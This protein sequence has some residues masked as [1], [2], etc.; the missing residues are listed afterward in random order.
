M[1]LRTCL[2]A[3]LLPAILPAR[4]CLH[5]LKRPPLPNWPAPASVSVIVPTLNEAD[6]VGECLAA[7]YAEPEIT[8]II[9]VDGGSTDGTPEFAEPGGALV[10]RHVR[11][12]ADGGGRGGQ[13]AAGL[14]AAHGD[15]IAIVHADCRVTPGFARRLLQA[16]ADHPASPGGAVGAVFAADGLKFRLLELANNL[17]AMLLGI[18]FGDQIQ[19][20]RREPVARH[21][22][23]PAIPLMEDI[24]L[25]L[26]LATLG[27]LLFLRGTAQVSPRR[28]RTGAL[29][30]MFLVLRL[31]GEYLAD[32]LT[33]TADPVRM[34]RDYYGGSGSPG[35]L[36]VFARYP[37]PGKVKARLA[38]ELGAEKAARIYERGTRQLLQ[39]LAAAG[40]A[41]R[42][43]GTGAPPAAF[44]AKYGMAH[45]YRAQDEAGDLGARML[46]C[47]RRETRNGTLP[48]VLIGSD[49]PDMPT[50]YIAEAFA[51]LARGVDLVLGP[52]EDGGYYLIGLRVARAEL[53][54]DI[55]WG[56]GEV[57]AQ[58]RQRAAAL[59]L[60]VHLLPVWRDIDTV[61]DY[62]A[63]RQR[64]ARMAA[65]LNWQGEPA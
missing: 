12:P 61:A 52:A 15:A 47:L 56:T 32:R 3:M 24:E 25:S 39:R 21:N 16:L 50:E 27:P 37:E 46:A 8:E 6:T 1:R 60:K 64:A 2:L 62:A 34:Y 20:F 43:Y 18:S 10:L 11:P 30:R 31:A 26:R 63:Y 22:L 41:G 17:R 48:A 57:L 7:L 59:R 45:E 38:T 54:A 13:I 4:R 44:A 23:Y 9:V 28:W 58:T 36:A 42:V 65:P 29:R 33:G 51:A 49:A 40:H 19:F 5:R 55:A 14:A 53:F 35:T